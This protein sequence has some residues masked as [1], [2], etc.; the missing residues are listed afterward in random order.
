MASPYSVDL[1]QRAVTHYRTHNQTMLQVSRVFSI[2]ERTLGRWIKSYEAEGTLE[3]KTGYQK[4][5]NP[6]I[7]DLESFEQTIES[8]NFS[9]I[10]EIKEELQLECCDTVIRKALRKIGFV[11]KNKKNVMKSKT[12]KK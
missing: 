9:T 11:K 12:F 1:R 8:N 2:G 4:G 6:V 10:M 7:S 3:P 5:Y